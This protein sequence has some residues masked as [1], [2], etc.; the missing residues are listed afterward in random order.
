MKIVKLFP[1]FCVSG[2]I[3]NTMCT[4][5]HTYTH[6]T[7]A[8]HNLRYMCISTH[9]CMCMYIRVHKY[10]IICVHRHVHVPTHI[11]FLLHALV[12]VC[13]KIW[14]QNCHSLIENI[15]MLV[16]LGPKGSIVMGFEH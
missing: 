13:Y 5:Y 1:V 9:T 6:I 16:V 14:E 3:E 10:I 2:E 12:H 8:D 15:G 11:H 4:T 7:C